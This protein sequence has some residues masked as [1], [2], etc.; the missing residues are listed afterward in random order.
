MLGNMLS[1]HVKGVLVLHL[2]PHDFPISA[3]QGSAIKPLASLYR[4]SFTVAGPSAF[5]MT[6]LERGPRGRW[7][8]QRWHC[9]P[10]TY[11]EIQA[12]RKRK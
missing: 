2:W 11:A 3:R 10:T 6:G 7:V 5:G 1:E 12:T 8:A 4:P 9:E